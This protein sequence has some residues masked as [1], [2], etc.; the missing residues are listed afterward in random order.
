MRSIPRTSDGNNG[1]SA[2]NAD[3][4]LPLASARVARQRFSAP[5]GS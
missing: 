4:M 1:A 3:L 2:V 5:I